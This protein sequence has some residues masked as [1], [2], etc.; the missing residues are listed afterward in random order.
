LAQ[1]AKSCLWGEQRV[2]NMVIFYLSDAA[3]RR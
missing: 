2:L 3:Q 1:R